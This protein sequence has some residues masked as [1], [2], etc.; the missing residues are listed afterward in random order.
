MGYVP[1]FGGLCGRA[2]V[3][4]AAARKRV[5]RLTGHGTAA[6][7]YADRRLAET[8]SGSIKGPKR[9]PLSF[10]DEGSATESTLCV[11]LTIAAVAIGL[12]IYAVMPSK[13]DLAKAQVD[14]WY[15]TEI[16]AFREVLKEASSREEVNAAW[17]NLCGKLTFINQEL[18]DNLPE[19]ARPAYR[20]YIIEKYNSTFPTLQEDL[21]ERMGELR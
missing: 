21:I 17:T 13:L 8:L 12:C 9:V 5:R 11:A 6:S 7:L 18:P 2:R 4:G 20:D 14:R 10:R 15:E 1:A 16:P 3:S 19:K